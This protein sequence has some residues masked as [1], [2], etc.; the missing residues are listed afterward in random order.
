MSLNT[1]YHPSI[2]TANAKKIRKADWVNK[3]VHLNYELY[4]IENIN[5]VL[6]ARTILLMKLPFDIVNQSLIRTIEGN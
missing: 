5:K 1:I 3:E 2:L 4:L 6:L